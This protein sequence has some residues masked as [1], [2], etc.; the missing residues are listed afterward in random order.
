MVKVQVNGRFLISKNQTG[1]QF[2]AQNVLEELIRRDLLHIEI[3]TPPKW[4][5]NGLFGHFWEQ[6]ILPCIR[7][8]NLVLLNLANFAP[9]LSRKNSYVVLHDAL[10][11]SNPEFFGRLYRMAS[12]TIFSMYC[13][14]IKVGTVSENS[15]IEISEYIKVSKESLRVLGAA[16][17]LNLDISLSGE[18]PTLTPDVN[19]PYFIA[20]GGTNARKNFPFIVE[21]WN[22][23]KIETSAKLVCINRSESQA[24][25]QISMG[26][27]NKFLTYDNVTTSNLHQLYKNSVALLW[28]SKC[29]GFGLPLL[30]AMHFGKPFLSSDTGAS[31]ELAVGSSRVLELK[32]ESWAEAIFSMLRNINKDEYYIQTNKAMEYNWGNVCELLIEELETLLPPNFRNH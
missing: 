15:K 9:V 14:K 12:K 29:E 19:Q 4:M 32:K 18:N 28:P 1:V 30:E 24:L 27:D 22:E 10:P 16:A 5:S 8:S 6:L 2:W 13:T 21:V 11:L 7:N 17:N 31:R 3:L 23:F 25:S 26:Q 20:F